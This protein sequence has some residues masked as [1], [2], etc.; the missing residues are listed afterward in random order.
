MEGASPERR[1]GHLTADS[2]HPN[3]FGYMWITVGLP[4]KHVCVC[5]CVSV[6]LCV[7]VC[8][9]LCVSVC[10]SVFFFYLILYISESVRI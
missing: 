8:V 4:P 9:Y 6:C 2:Q 3:L 10:V 1:M 7:C 5:M